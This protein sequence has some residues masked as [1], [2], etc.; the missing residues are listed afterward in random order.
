VVK[1]AEEEFRHTH[2]AVV[3]IYKS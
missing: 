1:R 2:E 3:Q